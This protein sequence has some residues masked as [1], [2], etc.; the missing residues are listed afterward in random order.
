MIK[1][2]FDFTESP[3]EYRIGRQSDLFFLV[4]CYMNGSET[5]FDFYDLYQEPTLNELVA[6]Y[7]KMGRALSK[8]IIN[9]DNFPEIWE[10]TE[11][12]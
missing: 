10:E 9:L 7:T 1:A 3:V 6:T 2:T 4:A 11:M 12:A 8:P 5:L